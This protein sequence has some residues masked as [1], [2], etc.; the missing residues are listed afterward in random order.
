MDPLLLQHPSDINKNRKLERSQISQIESL[1]EDI[2]VD[3]KLVYHLPTLEEI[4]QRRIADLE[5]LYPGVE[6]LVNPHSYHVSVT[7]KLWEL[8]QSLIKKAF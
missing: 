3:G 4:R 8:K 7:P 2:F 6:R 1:H 5:R